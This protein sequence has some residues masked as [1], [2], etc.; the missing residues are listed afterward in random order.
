M[1]RCSSSR[2]CRACWRRPSWARAW[3]WRASSS[4][5]F[6]GTRSPRRTRSACLPAPHSARCS[7]SRFSVGAGVAGIPVIPLASFAGSLGALVISTGLVGARHRGTPSTVLLLAGIAISALLAAVGRFVQYFADFTDT[8][9][10]V[11]WL[12]GSLDVGGYA[13]ILAA[14]VPPGIACAGFAMLP[15]VLDLI[16]MGSESA[17]ARGVDVVRT[18]RIA[19]V[20]AS[21]STG[22][23]AVALGGPVAFCGHHRAVRSSALIVGPGSS[24][25]ASGVGAVWCV[26]SSSCAHLVARTILAPTELPVG[27]ITAILGGPFFLWLLFRRIL[28]GRRAAIVAV[29]QRWLVAALTA[30]APGAAGAVRIVSLH[31]GR[32]RDAVLD[33]RRERVIAVSTYDHFPGSGRTPSASRRAARSGTSS[34]SRR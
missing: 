13:P 1:R 3:P 28:L 2:A 20:S 22:A 17:A 15:R 6:C 11:Q 25:G 23:F 12:M 10:S 32:H 21:L 29:A 24:R 4:R 30:R 34:G 27:I 31:P 19:L 26:L 33:G 14:L 18:E 16:S 8:F 9:R 7:P 5:R